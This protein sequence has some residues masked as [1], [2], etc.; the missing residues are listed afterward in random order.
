MIYLV[1][2]NALKY[3]HDVFLG[4]ASRFSGA[5]YEI[6]RLR[7]DY[8]SFSSRY[9]Q[10]LRDPFMLKSVAVDFAPNQ[11]TTQSGTNNALLDV[12]S[13]N[14]YTGSRPSVPLFS[15]PPA[16]SVPTFK[17]QSLFSTPLSKNSGF[18]FPSQSPNPFQV[19][20]NR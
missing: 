17:S 7:Q 12:P 5:H 18:T 16:S 10:D 3:Q 15:N 8:R 2:K 11:A 6:E 1:I 14:L 9:R 19:A 20:Q 4:L 13:N